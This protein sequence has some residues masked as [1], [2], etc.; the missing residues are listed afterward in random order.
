MGRMRA[1]DKPANEVQRCAALR[2][3]A[4]LDTPPE[5]AFDD[6]VELACAM[7][8]VPI[9]VISLVDGRR[10]W[11]KAKRG[12]R[13]NETPRDISLS[14]DAILQ[15]EL[16]IVPDTHA[17]PRFADNPLVIG[18]PKIRFYAAAPLATETGEVI[19]TLCVIDTEPRTITEA[20][21]NNLRRLA[22]QVMANFELRRN[23]HDVETAR[24]HAERLAEGRRELLATVSHEIRNPLNG[25]LGLAEQLE[26]L[27]L[28]YRIQEKVKTIHACGSSLLDILNDVLDLAKLEAERLELD[29]APFDL[30]DLIAQ[31][32]A[33]FSAVAEK[34]RLRFIANIELGVP[35]FLIGD[36]AR[37]RQIL[38]N[39]VG[40]A[41]KFTSRGTIEVRIRPHDVQGL[42]LEVMDTGPGI[43]RSA[44]GRLFERY[45]QASASTATAYGG[46][47]LGLSICKQL[48][49]L[50]GGTIECESQLGEGTTFRVHLPLVAS[51]TEQ[52]S[53]RAVGVESRLQGI[54]VLVVDDN[55]VNRRV[56]R[57]MLERL[58]CHVVL[59]E[60]GQ[61]AL[62][63]LEA[64][65][66][67]LLLLD[68]QMPVLDG[69]ETA[70]RVRNQARTCAMPIIALT[71][72]A[73]EADRHRCIAAGMDDLVAKPLV[74]DV[75]Q[76]SIERCLPLVFT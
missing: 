55:P 44:M 4:V 19:G 15:N 75:L 57:G 10:Q 25:I 26:H 17:D 47:G 22:R 36:A 60:H 65:D 37:I 5:S 68:C 33:L 61:A 45:R 71:G 66:V 40:N 74:S 1:P 23:V 53:V 43:P 28:P 12:L 34:K 39:L 41:L 32:H 72:N 14:S 6:L 20:Q 9:A 51:S 73:F 76:R 70:R 2:S 63:R 64:Q 27:E 29:V 58:G 42:W 21:Q 46:T 38:A 8:N 31:T 30:S 3:Y 62:E 56:A 7:C 16:F 67:D 50:M 11:F 24:R 59:A 18:Y 54:R 69:F 35:R 52:P 13:M 48:V 49:D